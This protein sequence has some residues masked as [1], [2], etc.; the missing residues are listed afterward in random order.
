MQSNKDFRRCLRRY[1]SS[2]RVVGELIEH[3]IER[4]RR[5]KTFNLGSYLRGLAAVE[6]DPHLQKELLSMASFCRR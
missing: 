6:S 2:N 3:A 5:E 4:A 1:Q